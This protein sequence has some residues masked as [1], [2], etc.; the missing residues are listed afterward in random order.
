MFVVV[1]AN[2][3]KNVFGL[4]VRMRVFKNDRVKMFDVGTTVTEGMTVYR[5]F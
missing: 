5:F 3:K 2:R 1:D 4:A